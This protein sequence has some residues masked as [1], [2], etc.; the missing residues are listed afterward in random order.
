MADYSSTFGGAAKDAAEDT[1]LAAEHDTEYDA[2]ATMSATKANKTGAPAST[3]NLAMLTS[4]GD[5]ADSLVETDGSGG[6]NSN[7]AITGTVITASTNFAG[8]LTGNVTGNVSGSSGSCTGNSATATSATTAA[9]LSGSNLSGD[10]TNSGNAVTIASDAVEHSML[11][12][13]NT[14]GS[15][16]L[17]VGQSFTTEGLYNFH[18]TGTQFV[19]E[20]YVNG[21][22]RTQATI[23]TGFQGHII[24]SASRVRNT[25]GTATLYYRRVMT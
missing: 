13:A 11:A 16:S 21:S 8:D 18:E 25:S 12:L 1:I 22:W 15:T 14:D 9:N 24:G 4:S 19:Y 3:N 20:I 23:G 10:V 2:I 6:I 5:L 7:G 17:N